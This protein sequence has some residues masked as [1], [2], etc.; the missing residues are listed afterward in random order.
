MLIECKKNLDLLIQNYVM[1][2][3]KMVFKVIKSMTMNEKRYFKIFCKQHILGS[4][5]KYVLLFDI[6]DGLK[7]FDENIIKESLKKKQYSNQ[8]LSSDM[9]YLTKIL[10]K[11]L[12]EFNAEKTCELKIKQNL[13]TIE[14]LFHKGM[15][16]ECLNII[17]KIKRI[18]LVKESQYLIL[19]L[20]N[21]EKKC[22]GYSKGLLEAIEVNTKMVNY[23]DTLQN[24]TLITDLYYKSYFYKNS[25]GK[26][27]REKVAADF[28]LMLQNPILENK[29]EDFNIHTEI[30]YYLIYSNYYHVI[31]DKEQEKQYLRKVI[32]IFDQNE[33]YKYENP[34]DYIS[35]YIR[36]IDIHKKEEGAIFYK[37]IARLRS[38]DKMINLQSAVA[39]ER[40]FLHTYQAELE[41]LLNI[42]QLDKAASIMNQMQ[43]T[44]ELNKYNIEPY[45]MISLYYIFASINCSL[46]YFSKGLKYI[47]KILNEHKVKERPNTFIKAEFLNIIIHYELKNYKLVL[48]SIVDVEKK[49]K[50][51]F[52]FN[53]LEKAILKTISKIS[54]NPHIVNEKAAF[55]KLK[56]KIIK[57]YEEDKDKSVTHNNYMK[58][59]YYKTSY[60]Q[61]I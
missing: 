49:Y 60:N 45:Y 14:I 15:Y 30:F 52:K 42:N 46:G 29:K 17:Q 1:S 6:M 56:S 57:K 58:Y 41:Y 3:N 24:A 11:S 5:N 50:S 32:A 33:T 55:N 10:M 59:I 7:E 27:S 20:M 39:E 36:I 61:N 4:Q 38:F 28:K 53:Y 16:E 22:L 48:K 37:D 23:F 8:Y 13:I 51:S 2:S 47:N 40:I 35:V 9:N 44:L 18:K 31:K 43:Q 12:N 21:W 54:E 34:L 19:E 25:I 26:I